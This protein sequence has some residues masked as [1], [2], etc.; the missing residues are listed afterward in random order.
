MSN[1]EINM[2][3]LLFAW[4]IM[5]GDSIEDALLSQDVAYDNDGNQIS[6][7][8]TMLTLLQSALDI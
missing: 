8:Y 1:D 7:D 5:N 4:T 3:A 2:P 6:S